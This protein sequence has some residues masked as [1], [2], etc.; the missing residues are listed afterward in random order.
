M[1]S[2]IVLTLVLFALA[3]GCGPGNVGEA[4]ARPGSTDV[5]V[6]GAVCTTDENEADPATMPNSDRYTCRAI[7]DS[8]TDCATGFECRGVTG[9]AMIRACQPIRTP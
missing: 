3:L 7:C 2:S 9:A 6:D 4:C 8:H 1:R 5:C